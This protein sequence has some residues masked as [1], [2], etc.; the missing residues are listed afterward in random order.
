MQINKDIL[1]TDELAAYNLRSLYR[2]FGYLQYKMS[3]F[4]EYALY[5]RNKDFLVS[6]GI[7][8]FTDTNGRLLALKPDVT[9]S[10]INNSRDVI[11]Q[12]QKMY[13]DENVYRISKNSHSYKEIKQTGLE[14]VGDVGLFEICEVVL[15]AVRSLEIIS[16]DYFF[17]ISHVGIIESVFSELGL[18]AEVESKLFDCINK[19]SL[20]ELKRVC[21]Q[22][23]I[24]DDVQ[25]KIKVFL[26][27]FTSFGEAKN[28]LESICIGN[29]SSK[30]YS[31][32][33]AI[34]DFLREYGIEKN[35][36]VDFSLT[37]DMSYYSGI[38]FKGY[39]KDIPVSV[40]SGG[41][42]DKL[43]CNMGRMSG[44]VGFA[45]YLDTLER[46][47][48]RN[49]EFDYDFILLHDGDILK[50][51]RKADEMSRDGKSVRVCNEIPEGVTAKR[52]I[53]IGEEVEL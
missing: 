22:N 15:L 47:D 29:D 28:A 49:K 11:G 12:V 23:C 10:I 51:L 2:R 21:C 53:S 39:I 37:N 14:C 20:D 52:I 16:N 3:K 13:Y 8:S 48:F 25:N 36:R 30:K 24:S 27:N 1:K 32:F 42:Y 26:S 38:A 7:I 18:S 31:E 40:L 9:L 5:I 45:V 6:E 46:L 33:C 41:Q 44:A 43:M 50:A 19:K 17:E 4:E 34:L 35:V